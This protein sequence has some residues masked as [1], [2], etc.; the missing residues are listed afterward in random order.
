MAEDKE[1]A[2]REFTGIKSGAIRFDEL[3]RIIIDPEVKK[4]IGDF[5]LPPW[6]GGPGGGKGGTVIGCP[7]SDIACQPE[8][9]CADA[10]C[11]PEGVCADAAC[12]PEGACADVSCVPESACADVACVP[13]SVCADIGCVPEGICGDAACVPESVCT[14]AKCV[15]IFCGDRNKNCPT[16]LDC[17]P[18]GPG[19]VEPV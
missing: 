4:G 15:D 10:A 12:V 6:L 2:K 17:E 7:S 9:A 3:G 14:D 5:H 13:E 16:N 11:V 19:K 1:R 8:A 18:S